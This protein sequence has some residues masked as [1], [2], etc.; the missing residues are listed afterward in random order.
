VVDREDA[1]VRR[2]HHH[3][4]GDAVEDGGDFPAALLGLGVGVL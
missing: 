3:D 1:Q 2:Q 4:V